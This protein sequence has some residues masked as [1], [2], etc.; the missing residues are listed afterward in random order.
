MHLALKI[1]KNISHIKE[2]NK[3]LKT[4]INKKNNNLR[5]TGR[6]TPIGIKNQTSQ[7]ISY[8]TTWYIL[9]NQRRKNK[10]K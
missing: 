8:G 3:Q 9:R 5:P 7:K 1:Y 6:Y 2:K 4:Q 10:I